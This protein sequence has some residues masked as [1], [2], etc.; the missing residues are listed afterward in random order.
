MLNLFDLTAILTL[1]SDKYKE[2]LNNAEKQG[3]TFGGKLKSAFGTAAKVG[4]AALAAASTAA[5]AF[6][7]SAVKAGETFDKSMAQVAATM[8]KTVDEMENEVGKVDLAWG[9][10]S[11]N[12]R[13]YAQEM[14]AHTAFSASEAADALNY[15]ALAGYDTQTSMQ[16]LP[17][18]LNL[19]AAGSIDLASASDMVTDAQSALGLSLDETTTMVDQMAAASSKSNTSVAQLGEAMLTIGATARNLSGGT[20]ELSTVLGVLADNGIKGA[21]GGTHLRNAILSL[22]TPTKDGTEALAKLNMT[23]ADMYDEAGNMRSLP[24]IFQKLSSAMEGMNQQSK[25]AI[26]SGIFNKT[27]L[28]AVNALIGTQADRWDELSDAIGDSK[29]AAQKMADTQLDNLAGDITLFKSALEGIQI[30]ISDNITP[31]LREFVQMGSE[32][33]TAMTEALKEGDFEGAA[34][35]FGGFLND[36]LAKIMEM[37]PQVVAMGG[38]I[39]S[40]LVNALLNNMPKLI[41][42]GTTL[43]VNLASGLAKGL[44]DILNSVSSIMGALV[45]ALIEAIPQLVASGAELLKGLS[46]GMGDPAEAVAAIID[47]MSSIIAAILENLPEFLAQ[48]LAIVDQLV[49]GIV[50]GIPTIVSALGQGLVKIVGALSPGA[51]QFLQKGYEFIKNLIL[52]IIRGIPQVLSKVTEMAR[53]VGNTFRNIDWGSVGSAIIN[54]IANGIASAGGAIMSAA[55]NAAKGALQTVKNFFGIKSPSKVF[56]DQVGKMLGAGLALGITDSIPAVIAAVDDM[57]DS[58][59]DG[60]GDLNDYGADMTVSTT[61]KGNDGA[62]G[63]S[64][65]V[66]YNYNTWHVDG[67]ENPELFASRTARQLKMKVRMAY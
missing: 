49:V 11:G 33:L 67:A 7:V 66:V 44:P 10:F 25:D 35:A 48:G 29:D 46:E 59:M 32:G 14:G 51:A 18:V 54:G 55:L 6:G 19:A 47:V 34:E 56:R 64:G 22:Q 5:V 38:T 65:R 60:F 20:Q 1:N 58:I 13:E 26:I 41:Q 62:F 36:A 21:E 23:Y 24:E 61:S 4:G 45:Q 8:G 3:K 50:S 12:L 30:A 15:M 16:M 28:A 40:A 39:L 31:A 53:N 2:G 42:G 9:T 57:D 43:I 63:N 52:G 17:N 37:L 27:D